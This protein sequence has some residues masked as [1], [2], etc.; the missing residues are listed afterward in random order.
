MSFPG[1]A[2]KKTGAYLMGALE[3]WLL[4]HGIELMHSDTTDSYPLSPAAH[5]RAGFEEVQ[6]IR[7]FRKRI[8]E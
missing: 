5:A 6:V 3:E 2:T 4:H 1:G 7:V 8:A